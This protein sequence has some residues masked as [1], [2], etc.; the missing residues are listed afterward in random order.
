MQVGDELALANL[1][2][3]LSYPT[4]TLSIWIYQR[5]LSEPKV[6]IDVWNVYY[7]LRDFDM[8][9]EHLSGLMKERYKEAL[10]DVLFEPEG[11]DL[12]WEKLPPIV[13]DALDEL[14]SFRRFL[15]RQPENLPLFSTK[16][17][18]NMAAMAAQRHVSQAVLQLV[19]QSDPEETK[20]SMKWVKS[21][22]TAI[23]QSP[24]QKALVQLK[25]RCDLLLSRIL[26]W[27]NTFALVVGQMYDRL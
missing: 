3:S 24:G 16:Q 14:D 20:K 13:A 26:P 21:A 11:A 18:Q 27:Q 2:Y 5:W 19:T 9:V 12:L 1:V 6:N 15:E 17:Y 8:V 23:A 25:N 4:A 22:W 10:K 7:R